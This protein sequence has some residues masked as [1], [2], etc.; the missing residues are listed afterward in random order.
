MKPEEFKLLELAAKACRIDYKISENNPTVF[1][2]HAENFGWI[3]WNP[4][5]NS[6]DCAAMCAKLEIDTTWEEESIICSVR[7]FLNATWFEDHNNDRESAWRYAATMVA[8]KIGG[9]NGD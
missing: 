1:I 9:L 6:C 5:T 7:M 2:R 3:E 4:L 8:A